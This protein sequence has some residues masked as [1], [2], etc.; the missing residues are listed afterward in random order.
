MLEGKL[1]VEDPEAA[2]SLLATIIIVLIQLT[3]H[4]HHHS[5]PTQHNLHA[6]DNTT[7]KET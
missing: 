5:K 3:L 1:L 6:Q 4:F 7:D 2:C